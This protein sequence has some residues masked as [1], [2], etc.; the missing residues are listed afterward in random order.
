MHALRQQSN[1]V[2]YINLKPEKDPRHEK[3]MNELRLM[4]KV[5]ELLRALSNFMKVSDTDVSGFDLKFPF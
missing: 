5:D 3:R 2:E 1:W 4:K